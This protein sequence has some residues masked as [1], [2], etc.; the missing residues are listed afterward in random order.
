MKRGYWRR[1]DE[2]EVRCIE[3]GLMFE[4]T[5]RRMYCSVTCRSAR[6][7]W[8]HPVVKHIAPEWLEPA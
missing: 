5:E 3:C 7:R 2:C 8:L 4:A 1:S 6:R